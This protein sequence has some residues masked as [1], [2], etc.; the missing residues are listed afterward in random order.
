M[1]RLHAEH[2][3]DVKMLDAFVHALRSSRATMSDFFSLP[4]G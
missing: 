4:Y 1:E 2:D 3:F